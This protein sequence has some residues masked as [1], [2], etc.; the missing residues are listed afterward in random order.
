MNH[1]SLVGKRTDDDVYG[2]FIKG[3]FT[4]YDTSIC[5]AAF[6]SIFAAATFADMCGVPVT[7]EVYPSTSKMLANVKVLGRHD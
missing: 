4:T 5:I 6:R 3:N 2:V 1:N 7:I